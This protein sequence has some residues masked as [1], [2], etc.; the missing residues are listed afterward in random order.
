M[1]IKWVITLDD[2][3]KVGKVLTENDNAFLKTRR[4]RNIEKKGL[5]IDRGM[6]IRTMLICLLTSQQRSG[7]DTVIGKFFRNHDFAATYV[8]ISTADDIEL[9]IKQLLLD[10]DLKRYINRI[11]RFFAHNVRI[12]QENNWNIIEEL[13]EVLRNDS[14]EMERATADRISDSFLGLGPKQSRNFLQSLGITRYEIPIDSRITKWLNSF[15]F[16]VSLNTTSL[17]DKGYYHF[18]NDGFIE[19]CDQAG[20]YPCL[21]D[22]AIFS[23]Y[24]DGRWNDDNVIF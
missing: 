17:S 13:K 23:S 3:A 6:V 12:M 2:I 20:T 14:K 16:P 8:E 5:L 21:L 7:P 22:A 24:D 11:S 18:V 1:E 9:F 10:N 15:G 4:E 19:L